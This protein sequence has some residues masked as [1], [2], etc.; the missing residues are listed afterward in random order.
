MAA[1]SDGPRSKLFA[2]TKGGNLWNAL[3]VYL[4]LVFTETIIQTSTAVRKF[5]TLSVLLCVLVS[6]VPM[7]VLLLMRKPFSTLEFLSAILA[8]AVFV[9][10]LVA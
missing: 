6:Y 5:S 10:T 9:Y 3:F 4:Y 8:L 2:W 7:R 1:A